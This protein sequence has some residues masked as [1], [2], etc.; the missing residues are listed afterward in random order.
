MW[1]YPHAVSVLDLEQ[2]CPRQTM[3]AC[4]T[5]RLDATLTRAHQ[6][7]LM[8]LSLY[9]VKAAIRKDWQ[10]VA[11]P[12]ELATGPERRFQTVI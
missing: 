2:Y 10:H 4:S 7:I 12:M 6:T 9:D 1:T 8:F 3:R 5:H 11:I